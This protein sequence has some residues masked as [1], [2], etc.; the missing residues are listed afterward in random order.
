MEALLGA[1]RPDVTGHASHGALALAQ[2][3]WLPNLAP[4]LW[5][6][7][8]RTRATRGKSPRN[9]PLALVGRQSLYEQRSTSRTGWPR[10]WG[11]IPAEFYEREYA[12]VGPATTPTYHLEEAAPLVHSLSPSINRWWASRARASAAEAP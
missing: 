2:L 6:T 1:L 7:A 4:S 5:H 11:T 3:Y 10:T 12:T 8:D 9:S